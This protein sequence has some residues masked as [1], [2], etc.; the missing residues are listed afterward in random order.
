MYFENQYE[1]AHIDMGPVEETVW[2]D[3][4]GLIR[5]SGYCNISIAVNTSTPT[6]IDKILINPTNNSTSSI[7]TGDVNGLNIYVN[8]TAVDITKSLNYHL[9]GGD[10]LQVNFTMPFS[11]YASNST[12]G[13]TV[14]T[15]EGMYYKE[16]GLP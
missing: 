2:I 10:N 6:R 11:D 14:F 8:G 13:V 4:Q 7:A 5:S 12:M 3:F 16:M 1:E 15:S 9:N